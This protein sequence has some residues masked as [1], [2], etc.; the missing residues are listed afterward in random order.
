[1]ADSIPSTPATPPVASPAPQ[2]QPAP[3]Q[4]PPKT[5]DLSVEQIFELSGPDV[6]AAAAAR[7]APDYKAPEPIEAAAPTEVA[8]E[9]PAAAPAPEP[10]RLSDPRN[11]AIVGFLDRNEDATFE[12]AAAWYDDAHPAVAAPKPAAAPVRS[13][14]A[15]QTILAKIN[16]LNAA[17]NAKG[18]P[19]APGYN[20]AEVEAL[21]SQILDLRVDL[22][23]TER[24]ERQEGV[25][26]TERR[27]QTRKQSVDKALALCP[28]L[29]N[30]S[31]PQAIAFA[32]IYKDYEATND[33]ILQNDNAVRLIALDAME[34]TGYVRKP[35][36]GAG[37]PPTPVAPAPT[38]QPQPRSTLPI[39]P[40]NAPPVAP[41]GATGAARIAP[42]TTPTPEAFLAALDDAEGADVSALVER[43]SNLQ[44][45]RLPSSRFDLE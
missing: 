18:D 25:R 21:R 32:R 28:E 17:I 16:E 29:S 38:P 43:I 26:I 24:E 20:T 40:N 15:S 10:K 44:A 37:A 19:R 1:M 22:K 42:V 9:E 7:L 11:A 30:A 14:P 3:A 35:V 31:S 39:R 27:E 33:P 4:A 12:D 5:A 36:A 34:E 41:P 8:A 2:A 13:E 23:F 6:T 45:K